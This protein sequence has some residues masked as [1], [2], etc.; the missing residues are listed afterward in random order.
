MKS[1]YFSLLIII[2]FLSRSNANSYLSHV[3]QEKK[4]LTAVRTVSPPRIDGDLT[5]EAWQSAPLAGD[6]V[7]YS[8]FNGRSASLSTEV[9][10]LYDDEALYIAAIMYDPNPDSIYAQLGRRD[11]D[12]NLN[13][14]HFYIDISTFND[15][16]NGEIFKVSASGV[17]S[18]MKARSSGTSSYGGGDRSWD[19]VWFSNVRITNEGWVA[20][21][22]IPFSALRFS[23][24]EVQTWGINFWREIR[25]LREIDSWS[26]VNR[27]VGTNFNHL[28][29]LEGLQ[30]LIPP[31]RLSLTPYLSGYIEKYDGD[32]PALTYNG[33]LD[34]K[35][36]INE[37]FT[38]DATLIPDFGQ[39]QSDDN[40]LNLSPYEV[41]Y[42][43][44]RPFFMEGTELF[45]RGGIFYSRRIGSKPRLYSEAYAGVDTSQ[46]VVSNPIE[47]T[48]INASKLSGRTKAG[49]GIGFFNAM[50]R[51]MFATIEDSVTGE[52]RRFKTEPFTN[53]NML[54]LDQSL[55]YGSY[56]SL[57]NTNVW[58]AAEKTENY[59]TANVTAVDFKLQNSSK[60]YTLSGKGSLSQKYYT[61]RSDA[62]G[63]SYDLSA[64][65][66]GGMFRFDY[67]ISALSD[68][69][70]PNDLGY[71]RRNNEFQNS[72][73]IAYYTFK[74]FWKI[75]TTRNSLTFSYNQLYTPR[76]FTGSTISF[77]SMTIFN[78]YWSL[79]VRSEYKPVGEDD[80]YEP[81]I[82]GRYY[83]RPDE[84]MLNVK[85]DTDKSK[86]FYLDMSTSATKLWSAFDQANYSVSVSPEIRL[87][88]RTTLALDFDMEKRKND[89]GY[90]AY[91][92]ADENIIFGRRYSTT[93]TETLSAEHIFQANSYLTFRLRHYWSRADYN[94]SFYYLEN[95]GQLIPGIYTEN[96]DL[97]YNAFN[98]DMVYTWRFAPGSELTLVWKNAIYSGTTDI[99]YDYIDNIRDMLD[100]P[101]LNSLSLKVLY[102]LD[103][104]S[105]RKRD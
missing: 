17:Q 58:R 10:I 35:Y 85:F 38:L 42:N 93:T 60:M 87:S 36:G 96:P 104:Q 9:R 74:P 8:P 4:R 59:Y 22:K 70:D 39:V 28:G 48:L 78:N 102:Y 45:A 31:V 24:T 67:Q 27:E 43:E 29:E 68:T 77:N 18:D 66:T 16:L 83:H 79:S 26:Y 46:Y 88:S 25:R 75:Y 90:I 23:Q 49:L 72:L 82:F 19:A 76:V 6:F 57:A 50:T 86:T 52:T 30:N 5:D 80:Y 3:N 11:S 95:N 98:I 105:L 15:G 41:K 14:D 99:F 55:K 33:G 37:S 21:I 101:M 20:E 44:R 40:V 63:H 81:R 71:L 103:Y 94:D 62:F 1:I 12:N 92:Y 53:Y 51:P 64:G 100:S 97:N 89:I 2:L 13:A 69:Y 32:K 91:N 7:Q 73:N 34:L 84:L 47:A 54:V 56:V 61:E 65:K